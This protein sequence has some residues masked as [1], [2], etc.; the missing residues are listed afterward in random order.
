MSIIFN[1][2][3]YASNACCYKEEILE[4]KEKTDKIYSIEKKIN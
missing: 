2:H 4:P 1:I 3:K